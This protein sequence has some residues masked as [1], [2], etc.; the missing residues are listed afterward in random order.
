MWI[1]QPEYVLDLDMH[2]CSNVVS[3]NV[4][5]RINEGHTYVLV[6]QVNRSGHIDTLIFTFTLLSSSYSSLP[7]TSLPL[8]VCWCPYLSRFSCLFPRR[9]AAC[10]VELLLVCE[11]RVCVHHGE[12]PTCS[13]DQ[14]LGPCV[15]RGFLC[16]AAERPYD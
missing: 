14:L 6:L 9:G 11:C 8:S 16:E 7:V 15:Q 4:T 12:P 3:V 5:C 13:D 1:Q 2:T 10:A